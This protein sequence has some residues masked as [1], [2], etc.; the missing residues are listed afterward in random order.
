MIVFKIDSVGTELDQLTTFL[1]KLTH[2][3]ID[4]LLTRCGIEIV[5]EPFKYDG[6]NLHYGTSKKDKLYNSFVIEINK[7][8]KFSKIIKFLES[9]YNPANYTSDIAKFHS[10]VSEINNIL[11]MMGVEINNSGKVIEATKPETIDEVEE[12]FNQLKNELEKRNLHHQV[13]KYCKREYLAK[14]YFHT[15]HESVKGVLERIRELTGSLKD[16]YE[17]LDQVLSHN[18]PVLVFNQLA[19]ENEKN[20]YKGFKKIIEGL[21]SMFRNPTSHVPRIKYTEDFDVTME[22]LGTVSMVHRYIDSCQ[23]VRNV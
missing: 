9:L 15:I 6:A 23:V 18:N 5:A 7:N 17:L 19:N 22:V 13:K 14:D 8:K 4:N 1:S 11:V 2:K 16:G 21:V 12:R 3:E 10:D 20:E